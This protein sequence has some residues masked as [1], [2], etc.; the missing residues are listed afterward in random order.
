M[1]RFDA[2]Y[3]EDETT[4]YHRPKKTIFPLGDEKY[5]TGTVRQQDTF[6]R[7]SYLIY[8]TSSHYYMIME[9]NGI[10]DPTS[11]KAGDKIKFLLPQ[12]INEVK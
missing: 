6:H 11:L 10:L 9:L 8:G 3:V 4:F 12:Y 2:K 7:L 5:M 1:Q